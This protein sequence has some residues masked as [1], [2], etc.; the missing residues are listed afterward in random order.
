[1]LEVN[2]G[3]SV[4]LRQ[5]VVKTVQKKLNHTLIKHTRISFFA[6]IIY[7]LWRGGRKMR[8]VEF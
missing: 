4:K 5:S 2:K 8:L 7:L 3:F 1:M 6:Y